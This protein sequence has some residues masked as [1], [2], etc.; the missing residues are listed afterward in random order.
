[1]LDLTY[2]YRTANLPPEG[3]AGNLLECHALWNRRNRPDKVEESV[4]KDT[5]GKI[6]KTLQLEGGLH[7]QMPKGVV[8]RQRYERDITCSR[9]TKAV[10][11]ISI[12]A[13]SPINDFYSRVRSVCVEL[14]SAD[15]ETHTF[16]LNRAD[17]V[18]TIRM[19]KQVSP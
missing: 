12:H 6:E 14:R 8:W 19:D 13:L 9:S 17:I 1:M 11:S 7:H 15:N 16:R 3:M 4:K 10:V 5:T 18:K 2:F